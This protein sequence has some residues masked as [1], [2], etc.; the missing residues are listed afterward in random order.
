MINCQV[1]PRD[2]SEFVSFVDIE[3]V[4]IIVVDPHIETRLRVIINGTVLLYEIGEEASI[5]IDMV[6][7]DV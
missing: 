2:P 5:Q 1:K 7:S 3:R 4:N 6:R